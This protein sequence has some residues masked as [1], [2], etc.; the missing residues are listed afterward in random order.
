MYRRINR[1]C[2]TASDAFAQNRLVQSPR[3]DTAGINESDALRKQYWHLVGYGA[4]LAI[5]VHTLFAIVGWSIDAPL[6]SHLQIVSIAI[7]SINFVIMR[8]GGLGFATALTWIDLL[9]HSTLACWIVGPE[10]GFQFYSWILSPLIFANVNRTLRT[11]IRV[12]ILLCVFYVSVDVWTHYM[13]PLLTVEASSLAM[14]RY[15]N[16][17]SFLLATTMAAVLQARTNLEAAE[18]LRVAADTDVLTGLIN[19][20]RMSDWMDRHVQNARREAQPLTVLLIDVDHFKTINDRY[21]HAVGDEVLIEVGARLGKTLRRDDVLARWGGEEF[22][23][24]LPNAD[25]AAAREIAERARLAVS[26]TQLSKR[27]ATPVT[28]TI[29]IA[30]WSAGENFEATIHRADVALYQGKNDGRNRISTQIDSVYM[31]KIAV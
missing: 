23:A 4:L 14:L 21:G 28:V 11:K 16:I 8:R 22:M 24:L 26:A 27:M 12:A 3:P 17:G 7:Y 15:F 31:H 13:T 30:Q 5:L 9:G 25:L 29:G 10:A 6:L 20:R 18:R 2:V 1:V 19:R